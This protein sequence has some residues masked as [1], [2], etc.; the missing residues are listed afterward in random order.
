MN[1][2]YRKILNKLLVE[3][4]NNLVSFKDVRIGREIQNIFECTF[5]AEMSMGNLTIQIHPYNALQR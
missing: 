5:I 3:L 2:K 4:Y 1:F